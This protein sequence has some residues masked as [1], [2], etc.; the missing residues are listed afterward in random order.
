MGCLL[1]CTR[2]S[3]LQIPARLWG[4]FMAS[5]EPPA[6]LDHSSCTEGNQ[7]SDYPTLLTASLTYSLTDGLHYY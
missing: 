1:L 4:G 5:D 2:G 3:D 6:A 7:P